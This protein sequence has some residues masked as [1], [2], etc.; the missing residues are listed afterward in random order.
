MDL[1]RNPRTT[2]S[3][4]GQ[5]AAEQRLLSALQSGR[6]PHAWLLSG[7]A[8]IGKATLAYRVA[9][10]LLARPDGQ[11]GLMGDM[12]LDRED[13]V[14]RQVAAGAHPDLQVLERGVNEKTGKPRGEIVVEE[15]RR[16]AERLRR[17]ASGGG[18]RILI[19]DSA[20]EMNRSA[21][22]ALLK[23]LEEPPPRALLLLISHAPGRLL[24]T[25][26]S[27]CCMLGLP[28]LQPEVLD[29]LLADYLP[30]VALEDRQ[31]LAVL[32]E[33]SIGQ[34][35]DLAAAGGLP[36]YRRL[37]GLIGRAGQGIDSEAAHALSDEM[38][39][40]KTTDSVQVAFGL[41]TWWLARMIRAGAQ[42]R[43]PPALVPEEEG[44]A[45]RLLARRALADWVRLWEKLCAL[46][47]SCERANLDRKQAF[48]SAMIELDTAG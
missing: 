30:D 8:G 31:L 29:G 15:V 41:L 36:L 32:A 17:T 10:F 7:K 28:P 5:Q 25:I 11:S 46:A 3:L 33:G 21:A 44:L 22:N 2:A 43:T 9:R 16:R 47:R 4:L 19:V 45:E 27:R 13:A 39:R 20:D 35:L 42:Q 23:L 37:L 34:A 38:L 40:S 14:F 48:L 24:P 1:E 6:L 18:W 26:R 12:S